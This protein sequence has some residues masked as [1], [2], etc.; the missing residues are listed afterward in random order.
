MDG[1]GQVLAV[2]RTATSPM[3]ITE[4]AAATGL[5]RPTVDGM[6]RTLVEEGR[7]EDVPGLS[8]GRP[9]P[10]ARHYRF[11]ARR[12]VVI[13]ADVGLRSLRVVGCDLTGKVLSVRVSALDPEQPSQERLAL[14]VTGIKAMERELGASAAGV[15][16]GVPGVVGSNGEMRLSRVVP[17]WTGRDLRRV[18]E[19][20]LGCPVSV[21][22]DTKLAALAESSVG[23]AQLAETMLLVWIGHRISSAIVIDGRLHRGWH[24]VAGELTG[25]SEMS[26]TRNSARGAWQWSGGRSPIEVIRA[27]AAGDAD[28]QREVQAFIDE[29]AVGVSLMVAAIDPNVIV[30]GGAAAAGG[31]LAEPLRAAVQKRMTLPVSVSVVTSELAGLATAAGGA[32]LAFD[33]GGPQLAGRAGVPAAVPHGFAGFLDTLPAPPPNPVT[34][35][36]G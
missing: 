9:G 21:E 13:G 27:G 14:L 22:N 32:V 4:L 26:W 25:S 1:A 8:T 12:Q 28:A 19:A 6:L 11:S 23:A 29:V 7:V 24:G 31:H 18:L 30:V 34:S 10:P 3:T 33:A 5:S 35:G 20:E 36:V 15:G 16:V 17:E 2:L